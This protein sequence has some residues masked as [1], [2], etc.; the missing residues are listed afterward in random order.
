MT[1][2]AYIGSELEL[3][4]AAKRWKLYLRRQIAPYLGPDVLEVGAGIGGTTKA[5]CRD[6]HHSWVCL[7]PDRA[8]LAQVSQA[9]EA[10][11][12]PCFCRPVVGTLD[13]VR[14]L[15]PFDTLLYIDVLEHIEDDL[16]QLAQASR[17]LKPGGYL[18]VLS[19][20]HPFL[21]SPFDRAIGHYRRYTRRSLRA[22]NPRGM[23]LTRIRYLDSAG[24]LASLGNRLV[25]NQSMPTPRQIAFWDRFLV[26]PSTVLDPL[27]G[28][29][30]GKSVLG[31]WR[32]ALSSQA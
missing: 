21:Y 19:P 12:L 22:L 15:A 16:G 25:L 26:R 4:A 20:A 14:D 3:F 30:I 6:D 9:I 17:C 8:L 13:D 1:D 2:Q 5:L 24:M 32:K 28:F 11:E 10:G 29:R 31:I 18:V 23:E 27:L 7:E